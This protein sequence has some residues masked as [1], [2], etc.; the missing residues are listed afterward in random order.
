M[1]L[2]RL[3]DDLL[4]HITLF[5]T[6]EDLCRL[7]EAVVGYAPSIRVRTELM[8]VPLNMRSEWLTYRVLCDFR[9]FLNSLS[10]WGLFHAR[11]AVVLHAIVDW[12]PF[13]DAP[14]NSVAEY[15][16]Y[17]SPP[18]KGPL[19]RVTLHEPTIH[20][21]LLRC[22]RRSLPQV[23]VALHMVLLWSGQTVVCPT[24]IHCTHYD[25]FPH[26]CL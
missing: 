12:S 3:P 18:L 24:P 20:K 16:W 13:S 9:A 5:L 10:S 25:L 11:D 19:P 1:F 17:H 14:A 15:G 2:C 22:V 6:G 26:F 23:R 8:S 4:A 21:C 7:V